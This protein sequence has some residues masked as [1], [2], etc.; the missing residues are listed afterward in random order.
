[1]GKVCQSQSI[2]RMMRQKSRTCEYR[3]VYI[4]S[5]EPGG[6]EVPEHR[7]AVENDKDR[8][9]EY[10]PYGQIWLQIAVVDEGLAVDTLGLQTIVWGSCKYRSGQ[11][12]R[13]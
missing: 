12:Q 4:R 10:A 6:I 3:N 9:P 1:M 11:A 13:N 8:S 5:K 2:A 7:K